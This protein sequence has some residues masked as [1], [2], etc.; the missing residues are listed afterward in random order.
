M[1]AASGNN[2]LFCL[3]SSPFQ[4]FEV[5]WWPHSK[6]SETAEWLKE[7][8][9]EWMVWILKNPWD[10]VYYL[11]LYLSPLFVISMISSWK[12]SKSF[13]SQKGKKGGGKKTPASKSTS[14]S[15][16]TRNLRS[17]R[18]KSDWTGQWGN[19]LLNQL[20]FSQSVNK[21][22]Y[23]TSVAA[24]DSWTKS[25]MNEMKK[26]NFEYRLVQSVGIVNTSTNILLST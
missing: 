20:V 14:K 16:T 26:W 21:L 2:S 1:C 13:Q 15:N 24:T 12:L 17:T 4:Y 7:Y 8:A 18:G 23:S 25:I 9:R 10:F 6:M 19:L 5:N 22:Q 3:D 11:F